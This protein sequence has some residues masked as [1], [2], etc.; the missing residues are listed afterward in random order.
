MRDLAPTKVRSNATLGLVFA[1]NPSQTLSFF[2]PNYYPKL[3]APLGLPLAVF[4]ANFFFVFRR[5]HFHMRAAA[6]LFYSF[7][8]TEFICQRASA[9]HALQP[10]IN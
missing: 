7:V 4:S 5:F 9:V 3:L 6:I 10:Y 2:Y 8:L 1:I